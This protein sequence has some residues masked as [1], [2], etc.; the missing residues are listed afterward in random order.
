MFQPTFLPSC[1]SIPNPSYYVYHTVQTRYN[2]AVEWKWKRE[3]SLLLR[4]ELPPAVGG[5]HHSKYKLPKDLEIKNYSSLPSLYLLSATY[6]S[7]Y[8]QWCNQRK[9]TQ[10]VTPSGT[11]HP[12]SHS[13]LKVSASINVFA[14]L[15]LINNLRCAPEPD[16]A[17]DTHQTEGFLLHLRMVTVTNTAVHQWH[18]SIQLLLM[19]ISWPRWHNN[20]IMQSETNEKATQPISSLMRGVV[21][22]VA[23]AHWQSRAN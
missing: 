18:D 19:E 13:P 3:S 5:Q 10:L 15:I 8:D 1:L 22:S 11:L 9:I 4:S 16:P 6:C 17:S 12:F 14:R 20:R 23:P 7:W 2:G 21:S